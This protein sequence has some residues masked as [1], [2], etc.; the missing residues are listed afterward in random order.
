MKG[1]PFKS[2]TASEFEQAI[3]DMGAGFGYPTS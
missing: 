3:D 1:Y 2:F